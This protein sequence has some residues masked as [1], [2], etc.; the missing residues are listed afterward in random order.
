[1][2]G[3]HGRDMGRYDEAFL[4]RTVAK[5]MELTARMTFADYC[6]YLSESPSEADKLVRS[7]S[8][9]FS[10][11]FRNP[12]T[13]AL[14]EQL[15]L[16][17]LVAEKRNTGGAEIRVWSAGCAGG[18][19]AFSLAILLEE[20]TT[21]RENGVSFRIFATDISEEAM[22]TARAG[23]F[24]F[25]AVQQVRLRHLREC[26]TQE[27]QTYRIR[28]RL[29]DR[30][31]VSSYDLLDERSTSPPAGIYGDFDLVVCSNLLFY[32]RSEVRQAILAKLHRALAA[33][34]YLVTGEAER[35]MVEQTAGFD[36]VA[37]PSSV[38]Q[39][40]PASRTLRSNPP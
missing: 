4:A 40:A 38:F 12:L 34:G 20:L 26:F 22:T 1:M 15:V 3:V 37:L 5:R 29:R 36:A 21:A 10:E 28:H 17:K 30:V 25:S 2:R 8:I 39:K 14:L 33:S 32:Y 35:G 11:F 7:L 9:T 6:G 31:D 18:Q 13:F 23:V 19:E 24:E 27:G 16:P